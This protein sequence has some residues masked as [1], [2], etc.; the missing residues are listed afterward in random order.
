VRRTRD[1]LRRSHHDN[2]SAYID[3]VMTG[4]VGIRPRADDV[5]EVDP[6][7][8]TAWPAGSAPVRYFALQNVA[9]HGHRVSVYY[10]ADGSRYKTGRGLKVFVDGRMLAKARPL[11]RVLVRLP[12]A[13]I[14]SRASERRV[15]LAANVGVPDGPLATASSAMDSRPPAEANDGRMWFFPEVANGWSP[16]PK[17][18]APWYAVHLVKHE[19][20]GS[21]ELDFLA[22]ANLKPPRAYKLE[23]LTAA[24]WQEIAGQTRS[25]A[26]PMGN[27]ENII[28]FPSVEAQD[29][30][31]TITPSDGG[32]RLVEMKVFAR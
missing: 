3:L 13:S 12:K 8:P 23:R 19:R 14:Q 29:V 27:G 21:I 7:L 5:L 9:Y 18:V 4:L 11:G 24:G 1:G 22:D 25:S 10:D 26:V 20:V 16:Q 30:R 31:V 32:L 17:D 15:D 28:Q 6:L 2:H